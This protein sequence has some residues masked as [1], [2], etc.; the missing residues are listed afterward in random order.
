MSDTQGQTPIVDIKCSNCGRE[1]P[2]G[3][4]FC[5][6]CGHRLVARPQNDPDL[7]GQPAPTVEAQQLQ[8]SVQAA[9]QENNN[10]VKQLES[11]REELNKVLAESTKPDP[12]AE[13]THAHAS[14]QAAHDENKSLRQQL[15]SIKEE[16]DKGIAEK[17]QGFHEQLK[18][19][20]DRA[21][22]L[23]V[24]SAGWEQKWKSAEEKAAALEKQIVAKAKE[25][26]ATTFQQTA[27]RT[28]GSNS[29][30]AWIMAA[31]VMVVGMSGYGA[32][33]YLQS[34]DNSKANQFSTKVTAAEAEVDSA[35][36]K[37]SEL[38][39]TLAAHDGQQRDME[40]KL[41]SA[42]TQLNN[43]IAQAAA[44]D[45]RVHEL[46]NTLAAHDGQ[47]RDMAGKLASTQTQLNDT[48]AQAAAADRRAQQLQANMQS[49]D[50]EIS[51]LRG[52]IA[53][54]QNQIPPTSGSIIWQG[55]VDRK[56]TVQIT[57]GKAGRVDSG[58]IISGA[59]P[60][61]Q[62]SISILDPARVKLKTIPTRR[63][64][65]NQF[66]F[67]VVGMGDVR[68]QINWALAQ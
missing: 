16:L 31:L 59:L 28:P 68:V 55:K 51:Q 61:T 23:K 11:M 38:T 14:L 66:S 56:L 7:K 65:W 40:G 13:L 30:V 35:N 24:Q 19:A 17:V 27:G 49:R 8:A 41:A 39:N 52:R 10:L 57:D 43:A 54:L 36:K 20:E 12:S 9:Q 50:N 53:T 67:E 5:Q 4:L 32:G 45:R 33:R 6:S 1:N 29:R 58:V 60:G 48:I 2:P 18:S 3:R 21:S 63:N 64:N 22:T 25:L 46:T 26:E 47:Q 37:I 34:K 42:Q 44:A 62:C 15:E